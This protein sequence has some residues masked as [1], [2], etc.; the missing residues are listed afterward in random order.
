M[1]TPGNTENAS[2]WVNHVLREIQVDALLFFRH[3]FRG[4]LDASMADFIAW[5]FPQWECNLYHASPDTST[6]ETMAQQIR[7]F[8][9]GRKDTGNPFLWAAERAFIQRLLVFIDKHPDLPR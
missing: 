5:E 6:P 2:P 3:F 9:Y 1:L 8:F 4:F 7:L